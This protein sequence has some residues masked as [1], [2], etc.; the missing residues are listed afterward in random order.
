MID[1]IAMG[2]VLHEEMTGYGIKKEIEA[3]IGNFYQVSYGSLYPALKKLTAKGFLTM[4]EVTQG[5][6]QKKYYRITEA[7]KAA[8]LEWLSSPLDPEA[9][10]SVQLMRLYFFGE[11]P[12]DVRDQRLQEHEFLAQHHLWQLQAMEKQFAI[13]TPDDRDYFE[14]STLYYGLQNAQNTIR[15]FRHIRAQKPLPDFLCGDEA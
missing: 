1:Y 14:L 4:K 9:D 12:K 3:G 10:G 6:R 2:M 13:E 5:R 7:G 15:W 8:F 11:L